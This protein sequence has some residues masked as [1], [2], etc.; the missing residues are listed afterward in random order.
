MPPMDSEKPFILGHRGFRGEL[1][2]TLPAFRRALQYADGIEFDVRMT[3]DG[4]LVVHHDEGFC[5]AGRAYRLD[6]LTLVELRRFHPLGKVIPTVDDVVR[7]F[8]G[9]I[10]DVDVKEVE[11]SEEVIRTL[12]RAGAVERAIFSADSPGII[13]S[14]VRECPDCRVGFSIVGYSSLPWILRL[15]GLYSLHVPIDVT[16]YIGYNAVVSLIRAFRKR[17]L[18]IFLW[19]YRMDELYWAPR[20]LPFVD[21]VISDNPA[22]MRKVLLAADAKGLGGE[23]HGGLE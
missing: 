12:E 22:R 16:S 15:K 6:E 21:A 23:S 19:N 5:S 20:F 4:K 17:G 14:L 1:E 8:P 7:S 11:T 2:N 18:R 3:A 9:A 13:L 10:F